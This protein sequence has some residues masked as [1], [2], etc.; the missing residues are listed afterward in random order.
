[1]EIFCSDGNIKYWSYDG[2][3]FIYP[4]HIEGYI[5]ALDATS[6][7]ILASSFNKIKVSFREFVYNTM[8]T[9]DVK[10]VNCLGISCTCE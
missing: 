8:M 1:M 9:Q 2:N 4:V 6:E 3:V 10:Y 7:V 5:N